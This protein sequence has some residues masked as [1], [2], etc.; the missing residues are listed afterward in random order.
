V[1]LASD[2]THLYEHMDSGRVFPTTYNL[3]EVLEGYNTL[4]KLATSAAHIV[5]GHDPE[6]MVRYPAPRDDLK[7]WVVRLDVEPKG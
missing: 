5:P 7:G 4:R 1:V 6:V 2:A 3:A